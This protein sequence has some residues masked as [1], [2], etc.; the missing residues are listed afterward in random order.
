VVSADEI[1]YSNTTCL[2][3]SRNPDGLSFTF[4]AGHKATESA[5]APSSPEDQVVFIDQPSSEDDTGADAE[6]SCNS[7]YPLFQAHHLLLFQL[8]WQDVVITLSMLLTTL[9]FSQR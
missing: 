8:L 7:P 3:K 2:E 5:E 6:S 4:M 1:Q 9:T